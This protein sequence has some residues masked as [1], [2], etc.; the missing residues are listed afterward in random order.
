MYIGRCVYNALSQWARRVKEMMRLRRDIL[1]MVLSVVLGAVGIVVPSMVK[2]W[3]LVTAVPYLV[4]VAAL[5]F[6]IVIMVRGI[7][8]LYEREDKQQKDETQQLIKDTVE[9]TLEDLG[10]KG[11]G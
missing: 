2:N 9:K 8:S 4:I 11:K 6:S 3:T 7:Q 10:L 1:L 5:V